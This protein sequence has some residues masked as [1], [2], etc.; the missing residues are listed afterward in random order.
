[1]K[2]VPY[3]RFKNIRC[4][5]TNFICQCGL[6]PGICAPLCYNNPP[7]VTR[8]HMRYVCL[9]ITVKHLCFAIHCVAQNMKNIL[10]T[11]SYEIQFILTHLCFASHLCA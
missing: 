2:Q 1:M 4:H 8:Q 11:T 6:A 9:W 7:S 5:R 3:S 10:Y